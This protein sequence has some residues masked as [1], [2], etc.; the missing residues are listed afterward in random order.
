M[1]R[2][3][4]RKAGLAAAA[5]FIGMIAVES[6]FEDRQGSGN[7]TDIQQTAAREQGALSP[8]QGEV[9]DWFSPDGESAE[10]ASA[11]DAPIEIRPRPSSPAVDEAVLP[12][13][14]PLLGSGG[15]RM[16]MP[17]PELIERSP[18]SA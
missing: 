14:A 8:A 9:P 4:A 18:P 12:D 10:L 6:G 15:A 11:G 3:D 5:L 1:I 2:I 16:P 7:I 17:Q 13:P